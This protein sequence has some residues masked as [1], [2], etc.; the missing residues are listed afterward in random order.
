MVRSVWSSSLL[1][2]QINIISVVASGV[3]YLYF[4]VSSPRKLLKM[5]IEIM[6]CALA[7]SFLLNS[8]LLNIDRSRSIYVLSW[9]NN[10]QVSLQGTKLKLNVK[11]QE[12]SNVE[13]IE[14]R[15]VENTERGLITL[16][17]DSFRLT[18]MGELVL[19]YANTM[20]R[21]FQLQNWNRNKR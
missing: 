21:I 20:A 17:K 6:I 14:S 13:A 3:A 18:F 1:Y 9:V 12:S 4:K 7:V 11:S 8:T 2:E 5:T 15:L 19:V 16:T 10:E